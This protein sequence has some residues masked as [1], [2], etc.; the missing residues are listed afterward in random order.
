MLKN[1]RNVGQF[2]VLVIRRNKNWGG[3]T[4]TLF[5]SREIKMTHL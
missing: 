5:I 1:K 3:F 2:M 4:Q